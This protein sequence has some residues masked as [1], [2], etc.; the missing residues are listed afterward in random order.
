MKS[1]KE[2]LNNR[3]MLTEKKIT[4]LSTLSLEELIIKLH[5]SEANTRSAA[6]INLGSYVDKAADELLLQLSKEKCIYVRL[7][8][9]DSLKKG[10]IVTVRKMINYLG[11]IGNNQYVELPNKVSAKK[12]FP[13]PRDIIAR[14]LGKMD[15]SILSEL[16]EV[17]KSDKC[18]MICE[19]IDAIGYMF[20]YNSRLATEDNCR[21]IVSLALKNKDNKIILWKVLKCLSAFPCEYSVEILLSFKEE[22]GLLGMEVAR[23]LGILKDR[24][25]IN[26]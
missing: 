6:A 24:Y 12:S 1:T 22:E 13:L 18:N 20:F 9:C 2:Q 11:K 7:A 15:T 4:E 10:N 3:G 8:I 17:M 25:G 5:N 19:V 16:I 23:S 14:T 21:L 26:I